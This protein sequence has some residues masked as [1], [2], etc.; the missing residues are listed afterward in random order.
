MKGSELVAK[1]PV[2]DNIHMLPNLF[3]CPEAGHQ[4]VLGV[5]KGYFEG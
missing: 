3:G 2:A 5:G 4:T 1:T